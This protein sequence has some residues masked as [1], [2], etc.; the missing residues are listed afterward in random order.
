MLAFDHIVMTKAEPLANE[1]FD[2]VQGGKHAQWGTA[3]MLAYFQ[4]D[5][6]IEWLY[7]EN[8]EK[9]FLS[10]N[11]LIQHLLKIKKPNTPFQ[12][13]FRTD[14]LD[15]YIQHFKTEN[16]PF[17]GP[18]K[19]ER[20]TPNGSKLSWQMVFPIYDPTKETLPFLIQWDQ[21]NTSAKINSQI[22][23]EISFGHASIERLCHVY[24]LTPDKIQK[25]KIQLEN[26]ILSIKDKPVISYTLQ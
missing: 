24:Q 8:K 20:L 2:I 10:T 19:A 23:K 11:P 21:A 5:C 3:N 12:I 18:I 6:Y 17:I 16:I 1:N 26:C 14:H 15:N 7:V 4:N 9:A 13:A 22:I 25:N